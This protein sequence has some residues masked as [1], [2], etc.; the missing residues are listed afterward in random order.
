MSSGVLESK[1]WNGLNSF[2]GHDIWSDGT[3]IFYSF[4]AKQYVFTGTT[5]NNTFNKGYLA[6][7]ALRR[8]R[9]LPVAY[10]YNSVELPN[11]YSV[12]TPELQKRHPYA[13]IGGPYT[14]DGYDGVYYTFTASEVS[15]Y[16]T[17]AQV[18]FA[19]GTLE[20]KH[21]VRSHIATTAELANKLN[22]LTYPDNL[23]G[24]VGEN[25]WGKVEGAYTPTNRINNVV[26]TNTNI[27]DQSGTT[28]FL[29]ASDPVPVYE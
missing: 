2:Q 29:S 12:Y 14:Y 1:T 15:G 7:A 21:F 18:V 22:S 5:V 17:G 28:L 9:V 24:E 6:G 27:Y 26:W 20:G 8:K 23:T 4:N 13:V 11:V 3:N 19:S 16:Y 25:A 10:L